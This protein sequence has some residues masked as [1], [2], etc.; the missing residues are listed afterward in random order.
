M[1]LFPNGPMPWGRCLL[2]FLVGALSQYDMPLFARMP[3][4]E[5]IA[6]AA[7]PFLVLGKPLRY[8]SSKITGVLLLFLI[9]IAG[10]FLSDLVSGVDAVLLLKAFAKP[11]FCFLWFLFFIG[12]LSKDYRPLLF[13]PLG[14]FIAALQNYYF[15]QDFTKD[16]ALQGGY[17]AIAFTLVPVLSAFFIAIATALYK[18]GHLWAVLSF[19]ILAFI[20]VYYQAPR[21]AA[22]IELINAT[23]IFY[24]WWNQKKSNAPS[25]LISK[26]IIIFGCLIFLTSWAVY[27]IYLYAAVN[28][29]LGEYQYNKYFDQQGTIFGDSPIGLILGGRPQ[30][31]AA[32]LGIMDK[33]F[34]GHGSGTGVMMS[35]YF[36]DAVSIVDTDVEILN[37]MIR[38]G[39][40]VAGHSILFEG[41]LEN[42]ILAGI[43]L[44][45]IAV[46]ILKEFL[47][48][49]VNDSRLVPFLIPMATSF[50]W[51]FLFSPFGVTTRFF[52]GLFLALSII[53]TT[54]QTQS[55]SLRFT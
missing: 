26:R 11:L 41:W 40:G 25:R 36:F 13:Y 51:A 48:L 2:I 35:D 49:V 15:P 23:I 21:S 53:R 16:Y 46:I 17:V 1:T 7:M 38:N 43:A 18:K 9:W 54:H 33:P 52:I 47:H 3:I 44:C 10:I 6:F 30:V 55:Q 27:K 28:Y 5:L 29:W 32:V 20:L 31:F 8:Y 34:I 14:M 39:G 50:F 45:M 37:M 12:L 4:G 19:I 42:G 22:A 24:I